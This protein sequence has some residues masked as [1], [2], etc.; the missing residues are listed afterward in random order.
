MA[1]AVVSLECGLLMR[2]RRYRRQERRASHFRPFRGSVDFVLLFML[3]IFFPS[4]FAHLSFPLPLSYHQAGTPLNSGYSF[5]YMKRGKTAPKE[6]T[7][8][9]GANPYESSIKVRADEMPR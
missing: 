8:E 5:W 9:G 3:W 7:T 6:D 2:E 4:S 1:A